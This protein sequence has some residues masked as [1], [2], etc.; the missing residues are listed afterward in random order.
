MLSP[1]VQ[2]EERRGEYGTAWPKAKVSYDEV[3]GLPW[4]SLGELQPRPEK[5]PKYTPGLRWCNQQEVVISGY[6]SAEIRYLTIIFSAS[7]WMVASLDVGNPEINQRLSIVAF[8][9]RAF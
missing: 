7:F 2:S 8:S 6:A 4:D 1:G 3:R 9:C 5:Q